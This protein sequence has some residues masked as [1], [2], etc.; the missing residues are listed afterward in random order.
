MATITPWLNMQQARQT[1]DVVRVMLTSW[2]NVW[3]QGWGTSH[4]EPPNHWVLPSQGNHRLESKC[5]ACTLKSFFHSKVNLFEENHNIEYHSC[6]DLIPAWASGPPS[7]PPSCVCQ[8]ETCEYINDCQSQSR[9]KEHMHITSVQQSTIYPCAAPN[10]RCRSPEDWLNDCNFF[11]RIS[12]SPPKETL[13]KLSWSMDAQAVG[14]IHSLS[15][16][17]LKL[18]V[19]ITWT[20]KPSPEFLQL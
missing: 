11:G 18:V 9:N 7:P 1:L 4:R 3:E 5:N 6:G 19:I 12:R 13:A 16:D 10:Y 20:N 8:L 17:K 2:L 15:N 14:L